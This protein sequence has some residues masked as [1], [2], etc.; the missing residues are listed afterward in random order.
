MTTRRWV[1][2]SPRNTSVKDL[3]VQS[4]AKFPMPSN[5][6]SV[7]NESGNCTNAFVRLGVRL[8]ANHERHFEQLGVE[9]ITALKEL[10]MIGER[11]PVIGKQDDD[12]VVQVAQIV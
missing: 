8:G 7:G 5:S 10:A 12:A 11:M 4:S 1:P 9:A 2:V 6:S 3:P